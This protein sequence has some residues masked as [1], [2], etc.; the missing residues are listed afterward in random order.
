MEGTG[1]VF[2]EKTK[3]QYADY[4]HQK[5]GKK[6][7]PLE[8]E[9]EKEG[10]LCNLPKPAEIET[11]NF[12]LREAIERRTSIRKYS[13]QPLTLAELSYLLW[14]SQGVKE[15]VPAVTTFRTVPSAGAC[16]AFETYLLV[17]HVQGLQPGLY[18]FLALKHALRLLASGDYSNTMVKACL[19]QSFIADSSVVFFWAAIKERMTWR[20]G[21]RGYRY[22]LL[23]A[24][25]IAQN[26]YLSALSIDCGV[27][28]IAAFDDDELNRILGRDGEEEFVVYA[29]A[30]G[31][32]RKEKEE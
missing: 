20:Y 22:L 23:D 2:W 4:S 25:H 7:P 29:A 8:K 27:C 3:Y 32:R 30:C 9:Y 13:A 16:H 6:R 18:R 11:G 15:I 21:E 10:I 24:G 31:K 1:K 28:A 17:N 19:G 5:M 26:L 12:D 14:C